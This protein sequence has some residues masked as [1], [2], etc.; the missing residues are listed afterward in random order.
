M[1]SCPCCGTASHF[2]LQSALDLAEPPLRALWPP[3]ALLTTCPSFTSLP[4]CGAAA[5]TIAGN[6]ELCAGSGDIVKISIC[7]F[8]Q[9]LK[10]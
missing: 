6:S 2:V 8:L 9:P 3:L 1:C 7:R 4:V 5:A 10:T